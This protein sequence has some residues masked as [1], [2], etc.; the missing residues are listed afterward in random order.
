MRE[1]RVRRRDLPAGRVRD[2]LSSAPREK[3]KATN[4]TLFG[5]PEIDHHAAMLRSRLFIASMLLAACAADD[6]EARR[7]D[8]IRVCADGPTV[9]GIDVSHWEGTVD[10]DQVASSGVR[11]A[12]VRVS[13]GL[14]FYDDQFERNWAEARRVGIYRGVYQYFRAGQDPIAQADLM[15]EHMG[16]LEPDDLP[17]VIDVETTDGATLDEVQHRIRAWIDYV[18]A[19]TGR[20]PIVYGGLYSWPEVTGSLDARPSELWVP[21]YGPTCPDIP[22]PWTRWAFFQYTSTGT[23]PGI[24]A[25]AGATDLSVWNGDER[26]LRVFIGVDATCGDGLCTGTETAFDCAIDCPRCEPIPPEGRVVEESELCFERWGPATGY[27]SVEGEGSSGSLLWTNAIDPPSVNYA[28]WHLYVADAGRYRVEVATPAPYGQT[29]AAPYVVRHAGHEESVI[30][31]QSAVD[32][33]QTLGDYEFAAGGDQWVQIGDGSG[34]SAAEP[35]EEVLDAVRLTRLDP[36]EV[37][38][39][40]AIEHREGRMASGGC[41]ASP[42]DAGSPLALAPLLALLLRRRP[43]R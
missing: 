43:R 36:L 42:T 19:A 6:D 3:Q 25:A 29:R 33:W 13:D 40:S 26:A 38:G 22:G 24:E 31:D 21:Q 11:F 28:Y 20:R 9:D 32:G 39:G 41:S 18:Q 34:E 12:F 37:R 17:P 10:W 4:R 15:L 5:E 8:E 30:V 16:A 7:F 35:I 2:L 14:H 27:R 23:V 1:P